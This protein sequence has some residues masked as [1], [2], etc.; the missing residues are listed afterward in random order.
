MIRTQG[1]WF[2][3]EYGRTLILRGVNLGGST[4]VPATPDGASW[5]KENF[6]NYQGVSFVGKPFPLEDADEHFSRLRKWGLTFIRLLTT[7]EA[8]EHDGPG[9]YD[10]EYIEYFYQIV[11]KADEHGMVVFIDPHQDVWSRWTGGDGAPAWIFEKVGMDFTKFFIT[12]AA[13]THQEI[14]DPYPRMIWPSNYTKFANATLWTLFFGGNDFAPKTRIDGV[15]VQEYLQDH[16][17]NA[18]KQIIDRVK[19]IPCVIGYDTLNEPSSGYIGCKNLFD[20]VSKLV[21]KGPS[22]TLLQGILM[23]NGFPQKLIMK[24][25]LPEL[26]PT[27]GL[28]NG[29]RESAY[30]PGREC[31]W[32]QNGL[33]ELNDKGKMVILKRDYFSHVDGKEIDFDRDYFVPFVRKVTQEFRSLHPGAL[34]FVD[35]VPAE[36]KVGDSNQYSPQDIEGQVHASHWYDGFTLFLQ[37]YVTWLGLNTLEGKKRI[38]IGR[39]SVRIDF[40]KQV[41]HEIKLGEEIFPGGAPTIIGET[42][43]SY[44]LNG[45]RAYKTGDYSRHIQAMDDTLQALE[46]TLASYTIWNYTADNTNERGDLWNDEDLS[47]FSRDQMKGTGDINDGGR[48][49][50]AVVRPFPMKTSGDLLSYSFDIKKKVFT[51]KFIDN[52]EISQPTEIF[53]PDFQYPGGIDFDLSDG[54]LDIDIENQMA[55]YWPEVK[56]AEHNIVIKPK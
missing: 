26:I 44:N 9:I 45:K 10:Q 37:R 29:G 40:A 33:W 43:I 52:P 41:E 12:G 34:M 27:F 17:I 48:A 30:L 18:I 32:K 23:A 21:L 19:D 35:P 13:I 53:I 7:W 24:S 2:K 38:I 11:K 6:Y 54:K 14:G 42:G 25:A 5:R 55:F 51:C 1:R 4:K 39:K 15:P 8:I 56:S 31:I 47:I 22:P 28:M 36:F 49:L 20:Y 50:E 3:D 16:Y 46:Q